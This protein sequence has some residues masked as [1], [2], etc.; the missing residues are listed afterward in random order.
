MSAVWWILTI[1]GILFFPGIGFCITFALIDEWIDRKFYAALQ[2]RIGPL[3]T[4]FKGILQPLADFL[5]LLSNEDIEPEAADKWGMRITAIVAL[6]IPLVALL[7]IPIIDTT[8]MI[9][10]EGDILLLAFLTTVIAI[11]IYLAGWFS[12]NRLAMP[13]TMRAAS[14]LLSYEI[15]ILLTMFVVALRTQSL[16][17]ADIVGW[18]IDHNRPT[19]FSLPMVIFF[20]IFLLS[21]QAELERSP[22]DI[23]TA[24]TEIVGGWE[25][26]Y[27]GKKLGFFRLSADLQLLY[28]AGMATTLFLGGPTGIELWIPSFAETLAN[29]PGYHVWPILYY[30]TFFLIKSTLIIVILATMRALMARIRIEQFLEFSWKWLIPISL[31]LVI[32][33]IF[34]VP[35]TDQ[36]IWSHW[37][38]L[39]PN[40]T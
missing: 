37:E 34:W 8:G 5:K 26:E 9:S 17:L 22:F 25:V 32:V 31:G 29:T 1:L 6:V 14:Q 10:F 39:F 12:A 40:P 33:T 24:E 4:G 36:V 38:G 28:A 20:G 2:D 35:W 21:T 18:Q 19:L 16:N 7:F 23:P 30:T 3:H 11:A 15:P 27:S 13:G